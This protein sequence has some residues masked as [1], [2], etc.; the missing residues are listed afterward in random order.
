MY[1]KGEITRILLFVLIL[2]ELM[3]TLTK[4]SLRMFW[5]HAAVY[6][7]SGIVTVLA[8]GAGA[9]LS[10]YAP[11]WMKEFF[12]ALVD[13][14]DPMPALWMLLA[15]GLTGWLM[16]RIAEFVNTHF[17]T[18]FMRDLNITCFR[19][20]HGHGEHFFQNT[21]VGSLVKRVNKFVRAA[22]SI[23]DRLY[24]DIMPIILRMVIITWILFMRSPILAGIVFVWLVIIVAINYWFSLYK[25]P[26]DVERSQKSS[27]VSGYIADTFGNHSTIKQ[28]AATVREFATHRALMDDWHRLEKR[29]WTLG[30]W[31]NVFQGL[32]TVGL[33]FGML[34]TAMR[35]Y[36]QGVLTVGDFALIQ[37][38]LVTIFAYMFGFARVIRGIYEQIAEAEEMTEIFESEHEVIDRPRATQLQVEAGAVTFKDVTFRYNQ[39]RKVLSKLNLMIPAGKKIGLI[40]PS[41]AGKSTAV[42]LLLRVHDLTSGKIEIDGQRIDRVTQE[43]L[44]Q[45][46]SF[47]PQDPIL[48]H[49]S[50]LDNIRYARPSA[51]M[52]DVREAARKA[53]AH[54]FISELSEGYDTLVGERGVKLSGGERQRIAI[55]R[56]ILADTP[57]LVLDEATSALDSE[58]EAFIQDALKTL[59]KGKTVISIA[60]RLSTIMHMDNI[61]VLDGGEVREQGSHKQLLKKKDGLYARLWNMQVGGYMA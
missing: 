18:S 5:Q 19:Y 24:W 41:G 54:G 55:A 17:Q 14:N 21:F 44:H 59:M 42:K 30:N 23:A 27:E 52:E 9:A 53:H 36:Q 47:V 4:K 32:M 50:L 20:I 13:G 45:A 49:R 58:S 31:F 57:I 22:E 6:K 25:L 51:S 39:T 46:I 38:Y 11:L 28:F 34:Y 1:K 60:H 8:I 40:G 37:A 35:L 7:V 43:S 29:S 15:V 10:S 12:D 16:W 61:V 2:G 33:E 3:K 26:F 48:F 56:A